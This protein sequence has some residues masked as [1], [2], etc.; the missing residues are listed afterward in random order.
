MRVSEDRPAG[1]RSRAGTL[2]SCGART[3]GNLR[4]RRDFRNAGAP[5]GGPLG[6]PLGP[7]L[8]GALGGALRPS[9]QGR[10]GIVAQGAVWAGLGGP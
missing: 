1:V 4:S 6:G 5:L 2:R 7:A 10:I 9:D 3:R 8:G